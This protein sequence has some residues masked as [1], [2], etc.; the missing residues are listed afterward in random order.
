MMDVR[1]WFYMVLGLLMLAPG[2]ASGAVMQADDGARQV[3]AIY[4]SFW[5]GEASWDQVA[6]FLDDLP[7]IGKYNSKLP[8]TA[9]QHIAQAQ[10]AGISAFLVSWFGV[11][12]RMTTT[13]ALLNLLD[14]AAEMDFQIGVLVDVYNPAFNREFDGLEASLRYVAEALTAHPAYLHH[15]GRPVIAFAFQDEAGFSA[16]QWGYLRATLDPHRRMWWLAEGLNACCLYAGAMDGMYA[17][18]MAWASGDA[19]YYIAERNLL[20]ERGGQVY[21]PSISP[22]WDETAIARAERRPRPTS[23]RDRA[24]GA[25][26]TRAWQAALRTG[27]EVILVTSWNEFMENS[28]IEPSERYGTLLT[29][30]LRGLV[31]AWRGEDNMAV[32]HTEPTRCY[33]LTGAWPGEAGVYDQPQG[34]ARI[35]QLMAGRRYTLLDEDYGYYAIAWQGATGWVPFSEARFVPC[36]PRPTVPQ[37]YRSG[38]AETLF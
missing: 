22:G 6:P 30:T 10:A 37:D 19:D 8:T 29:E 15:A 16:Q 38:I 2:G 36:G 12:E 35:G 27:A 25:F 24:D 14:R 21:I 23:A 11:D 5:T 9:A 20:Y 34:G 3:W 33:A 32:A 17:F 18:N 7:L 13:P 4:L 1:R 28:H 31:G 26:L